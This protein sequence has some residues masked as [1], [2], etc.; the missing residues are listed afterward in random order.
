LVK[1]CAS[2]ATGRGGF[3]VFGVNDANST[4]GGLVSSPG[5]LVGVPTN[6]DFAEHFGSFPRRCQPTLSWDFKN[7]PIPL[8][9]GNVIHVVEIHKGLNGPYCFE[10]R[11]SLVFWKRTNKG[12]EPMSYEETRLAFIGE[13]QRRGKLL[14]LKFELQQIAATN[15]GPCERFGVWCRRRTLLLSI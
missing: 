4:G 2:F 3:L 9:N 5:R 1:A 14:M 11:E 12:D 15:K 6:V 8:S 10:E 7:P 13:Q